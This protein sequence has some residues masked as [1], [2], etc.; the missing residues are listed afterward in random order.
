MNLRF[1]KKKP[2]KSE[3][4]SKNVIGFT[5]LYRWFAADVGI[6]DVDDLDLS[7]GLM[8]Q[9]EDAKEMEREQSEKRLLNV[10]S[11]VPFIQTMVEISTMVAEKDYVADVVEALIGSSEA[12]ISEDEKEKMI[13]AFTSL[14]RTSS[15]YALVGGLSIANELGIIRLDSNLFTA[16][17][18][19]NLD[20][21]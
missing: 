10:M 17:R 1:W 19:V 13:Q 4:L 20:E 21:R 14:V 9:S 3:D 16:V 18:A 2:T 5:T 8:P 12:D 15:M 11:T 6:Q 7:L